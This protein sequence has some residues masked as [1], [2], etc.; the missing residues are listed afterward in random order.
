MPLVISVRPQLL[1]RLALAFAILMFGLS[2]QAQNGHTFAAR[3]G[4]GPTAGPAD[5]RA[6]ELS[7][8]DKA[9]NPVLD[10]K[11]SEVQIV[12]GGKQ[13]LGEPIY[14]RAACGIHAARNLVGK[15]SRAP[16]QAARFDPPLL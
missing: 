1:V 6:L 13:V 11:P 16:A 12:E 15:I 9:G 3:T 2:A 5:N 4:A 10:L 7:A 14:S 8:H